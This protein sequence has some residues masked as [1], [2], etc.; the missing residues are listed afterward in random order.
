MFED[1]GFCP[2]MLSFKQIETF[3]WA[4]RLGS[5]AR[6]AHQLNATQSAVSMRIQEIE[7]R[8]QVALF[9]RSQR[10]ARLTPEG[11]LLLPYAEEVVLAMGRLVDA[12]AP[13]ELRASG[14]VRLGVTENVAVTWLADMV[15][16]LKHTHPRMQIELEIGIS[17]LLEEKLYSRDLDMALAACELP[18][19]QFHSTLVQRINFQWMC[20]PGLEGVPDVLRPECFAELPILAVTRSWEARGSLL[21]WYTDN[22]IHF[23]D[24]TICNTFRTTASMAAAG[25]GLA[26]LPVRSFRD[27]IIAKRLRVI[28]SRPAMPLLHIYGVHPLPASSSI[29]RVI[30]SAAR[31]A[32]AAYDDGEQSTP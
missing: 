3:F 15:K 28:P 17:H 12:M 29:Y 21:R 14:R 4:A 16:Y 30:E 19:S 13:D 20:S 7:G 23:R 9:D 2:A 24:V 10:K 1:Y 8:L 11:A 31:T 5:F 18:E 25:L 27:E 22:K 6:T 26:Y 32:A